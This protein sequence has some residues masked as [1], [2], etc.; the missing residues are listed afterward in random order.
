M[1]WP[2][3]F[4]KIDAAHEY[5]HL[6]Q[7]LTVEWSAI[8]PLKTMMKLSRFRFF[9]F[10]LAVLPLLFSLPVSA[11]NAANQAILTGRV[12]AVPLVAHDPY[13]SVWS[14]ADK[15]TDQPT[16]HWTGAEQPL[17]GLVRIDGKAYRFC[18]TNPVDYPALAQVSNEITP[19][20][21]SYTFEGDG[22]RLKLT[23]LSPLLPDDIEVMS[24]PV[25]YISLEPSSIDGKAHRVSVYFDADP[26]LAVDTPNQQVK[27][28]RAVVKGLD[29]IRVGTTT[30]P[31]LRRRG[32]N[33][34]IDW[35]YAY[36]AVPQASSRSHWGTNAVNKLIR[37]GI[38][39]GQN[40][41]ITPRTTRLS[42]AQ[43]G[44]FPLEDAALEAQNAETAPVLAALCD[45]GSVNKVARAQH[46]LL[47]YDD[48]YSIDLM[49]RQLRPFWRRTGWDAAQ[50][51]QTAEK[52]FPSL[53]KRCADFD[54]ALVRDAQNIGGDSYARLI[55][56]AYRQTL[57]AHKIVADDQGRALHF[58]KENFS[59]GCIATVDVIY[60]ASPFFLL[61]N[62]ELLKGQLKPVLDY[63][64]SP[65]WKWPF[66]PHDLGTY[67]LATGQVYGG[68][69]RTEENQMPVE[70]SGNMLI[71]L[72]ALAK[73]EGN[74]EFS[75]PYWPQLEKWAAYLKDKGLDPENQLSTDDF[76]GHL[77]HNTNLSIK[78]IVAL[79]GYA[80]LCQMVGRN[81]EAKTYRE[82]AQEM[83]KKWAPM[84][85][86][87]DHYRLAF[88]KPGTW[89]QKYNIV[90][91]KLL[92]LG[93]FSP[94]ITKK[95]LA[96]YSTKMAPYGLP[97]DNR[98][99]YTKLDWCVWTATLE[100]SKAG[101]EKHISP[102]EKFFRATPQRV[103]LSDWYETGDARQSGFQARSVVGGVFIKFLDD[104]AL[105]KKW[106]SQAGTVKLTNKPT[107]RVIVIEA[108]TVVPSALDDKNLMWRYVTQKPA[109][110]WEKSTYADTDWKTGRGGFGTRGTPGVVIGTEWNSPDIWLR[111][112]FTL[113]ATAT[114]D[115]IRR[116]KLR[117]HHDEDAEV[118]INGVLAV[119]VQGYTSDYEFFPIN[120]EALNTLK[121]GENS[122]AVHVHQTGGGQ[123]I[124][125]GLSTHNEKILE[126]GPTLH[127]A[128]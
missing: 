24:R 77:A 72:A 17:T 7:T 38:V 51:L 67:P 97:L 44:E 52:D 110:G 35:G 88:D 125:V 27:A 74:A 56:L 84:A 43:S 109:D 90:W 33:I 21:S 76:A 116:M 101:F 104:A 29:A 114:P 71:M 87:G 66:A 15:L 124:D 89:S 32:D 60:P 18:G 11:Q 111:R 26:R 96:Y 47:A 108:Q 20:R 36:L 30:Q 102:L 23:F 106:V 12:P 13:F 46:L 105:W 65:R 92:N 57:A 113:P 10:C 122:I 48:L 83:A 70:E 128:R 99:G 69:E 50:L 4:C 62:P 85:D 121:P 82:L 16:K 45:F 58:S 112:T 64:A 22:V 25:T 95:E 126:D 39:A 94:E 107:S 120:N 81:S 59:N 41:V 19:T 34:R 40:A 75:R 28:E 73:V 53:Q 127:F 3:S 6:W 9:A 31:I 117:M 78:A 68:G 8:C 63:A 61:L 93:L 86:D 55:A 80:Q 115:V 79:G 100:G 123:Y 2:I 42:F 119:S 5:K 91:D 118:Y 103:P 49:G 98:R 37:S 54:T 1:F 14:M